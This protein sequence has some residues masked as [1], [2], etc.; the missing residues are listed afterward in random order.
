MSRGRR[1]IIWDYYTEYSSLRDNQDHDD[2]DNDDD[3]NNTN[4]IDGNHHDDWDNGDDYHDAAVV[5]S[6]DANADDAEEKEG[7]E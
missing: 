7:W 5:I 2:A 1:R 6:E 3:G 4:G